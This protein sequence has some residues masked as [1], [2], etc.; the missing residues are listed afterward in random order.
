M[1]VVVVCMI[2]VVIKFFVT[3]ILVQIKGFENF[4]AREMSCGD[5]HAAAICIPWNGEYHTE[6]L[7][8]F[9]IVVFYFF[10]FKFL[11]FQN[12]EI[13]KNYFLFR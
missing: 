12:F 4:T 6:N 1:C 3:E 8:Q 10:I 7:S 2:L 5:F 13:I 9:V 11:F